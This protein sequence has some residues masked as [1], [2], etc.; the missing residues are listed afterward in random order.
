LEPLIHTPGVLVLSP[1]GADTSFA[2]T[3]QREL[4]ALGMRSARLTPEELRHRWPAMR[5]DD[6]DGASWEPDAGWLAATAAVRALVA[7]AEAH[8][9]LLRPHT[10]VHRVTAT[11]V[12][13]T[14]GHQTFDRV[15][16]AAGPW[17]GRLV[18][19]A[20]AVPT[21]QHVACFETTAP[22]ESTPVWL[23][24]L[25]GDGWYGFPPHPSGVL[26]IGQ[27]RFAAPCD[28]DDPRIPDHEFV[29]LARSALR[30]RLPGIPLGA[31]TAR[32]CLYTCSPTADLALYEHEGVLIAGMGSGHGFKFGPAIGELVSTMLDGGPGPDWGRPTQGTREV[33]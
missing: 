6:L 1:R 29:E 31:G 14:D 15:V 11:R 21:R 27:H 32:V 7:R 2:D 3:S 16:V 12:T 33:W 13:T 17:L 28:A 25:D 8:G 20:P 10:A 4:N 24:D 22:P 19:E 5:S 26:K 18:P 23:D 30:R 9:A